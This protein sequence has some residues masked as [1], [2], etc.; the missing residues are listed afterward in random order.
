[1]ED[2][3]PTITV[4][5]RALVEHL[6]RSGD[7]RYDLFG[8]VSALEGIRS[9]QQIQ[10]QRPAGYLS[11]VP[12][13]LTTTHE[14]FQLCI[15]GRID[16][17]LVEDARTIIEEIKST[18]RSIEELAQ[19]PNPLH[20][21]QAKCYAYL[22]AVREQISPVVVR[23]TYANPDGGWIHSFEHTLT[24]ADLE[25]FFNDLIARYT[26]WLVRQVR[27]C[28]LRDQSIA[29]LAFP[30]ADYR[31]G[32]RDMAVA[33]YRTIRER[34]H[35]LVQAATGIGK[36]MA[37]LFPAVKALGEK[38]T[39]KVIFL[40]ARTTG[41]LA[42]ESALRMLGDK[43]LR[44]KAVT[45]TAKDKICFSPQSSCTPDE[46]ACARG[47]YDRVH[48]AL[49]DAL[50]L[51]ALTREKIEQV[52]TAH[53]ICPFEFSLELADWADCVIC[54]YNYAFSPGV[55]LQRLFEEQ[56]GAHAVLVD[57]A[58]NLVDRSREMFSAQLSKGPVLD[59]R[60]LLKEPLPGIYRALGR[61]NTWMVG[62]RRGSCPNGQCTTTEALP[63]EL[64]E[65]L[66]DFLRMA[67]KWLALNIRTD[68]REALLDFF[69][70]ALRFVRVAE[71]FDQRYAV[72]YDASGADFVVKLFCIDPSHQLQL[73]WQRCRAAV[74]FSAT[75]TPA[76]YFQTVL[77]CSEHSVMLNLSSPFAPANLAVMIADH[78]ST[79]YREREDSCESVTRIIVDWVRQHTGHYLLFFP[80]YQYMQM[81]YS[82]FAE[83]CAD[84]ETLLQAPEMDE[85]QRMQ[86]LSSFKQ[87]ADRT[88][89]GFA[90]MGGIF[91]EG[92]DLKGDH[93]AAVAIVGVGLPGINPERDLIRA[94]YDKVQ[95]CGFAFAYQFPGINRVLQAAGRVIRSEQDRGMVLLIDRRYK[96]PRY[97]ALLPNH[98]QPHAVGDEARLKA[99]VRSF[100][101]GFSC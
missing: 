76:G 63:V 72:I 24:R 49:A 93:L 8:S 75:L 100:W 11:E 22:W 42:A 18:R 58:H 94:Y 88:R 90:V 1:L 86:F 60:R 81:V 78:I 53:Q 39:A 6:L 31:K 67:E 89:V 41:R 46:C 84:I 85:A 29:A 101:D 15:T 51:D 50:E 38:L 71:G 66:G 64:V 54:D 26:A 7:L 36:T 33:V 91:G 56:S 59:L 19:N 99:L 73:A 10:R 61:I 65:R 28:A 25:A 47:Y 27:W 14:V 69:F 96:E 83:Q 12:V 45:L 2:S 5:V 80:S 97:R 52:A 37:V 98:W 79:L 17:V 20:W 55:V 74:L 32:Q 21:G 40:T 16:G 70:E 87:E 4:A 77:G 43:G 30:F 48:A 34:G 82:C 95:G 92:I 13:S 57:E 44:I 9:H 68:F 62:A 23:L 3:K 35:L